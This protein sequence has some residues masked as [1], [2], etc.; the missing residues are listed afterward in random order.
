MNIKKIVI[1][2]AVEMLA[3]KTDIVRKTD[4]LTASISSLFGLETEEERITNA[5]D[6]VTTRAL[7]SAKR[8]TV[9]R[10]FKKITKDF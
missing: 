5:L 3:D 7:D 2:L 10:K 1:R 9:N 6:D 4:P 8:A